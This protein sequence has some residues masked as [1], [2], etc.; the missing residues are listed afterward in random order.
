MKRRVTWRLIGVAL[1]AIIASG[2]SRHTIA[3]ERLGVESPWPFPRGSIESLGAAE[4]AFDGRLSEVWQHRTRSKPAGPLT[5]S[6]GQ[7]LYSG[8][9]KKFEFLSLKTGDQLGKL[10]SGGLVQTGLVVADT[11]GFYAVAAW[12]NR[13]VA[14]NM[15]TGKKVWTRPVKDAAPGTILVNNSLIISSADGAILALDPETGSVRWTATGKQRCSVPAS[16]GH[17]MIFQPLD[18]GELLALEPESGREVYRVTF[19]AP[20]AAPVAVGDLVYVTDLNGTVTALAPADGSI[21]WQA[22]KNG[23][24]IW[25][26]AAVHNGRLFVGHVNG[27]LVCLEAASGRELWRYDCGEVLRAS[28]LAVSD[29]VVIGSMAGSVV[30]LDAASG[31]IVDQASLDGAISAAPITDGDRVIVATDKGYVTCYGTPYEQQAAND[32][33]VS[34]EDGSQ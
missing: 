6:A 31:D 8:T 2:C 32:Q 11:L 27:E 26:S 19:A 13:A 16:A 21:V 7:V 4:G 25:S 24:A 17:G 1:L 14:V 10:K 9:K 22:R 30:V 23:K 28:P 3:D 34:S 12:R 33:R 15:R 18:G 5:L 20:I 29:F